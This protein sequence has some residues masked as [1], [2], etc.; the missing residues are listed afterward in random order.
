MCWPLQE[1]T[2]RQRER[3]AAMQRYRAKKKDKFLKLC[4]RTS[5]GQPVMKYHMHFLL[6]KLEKQHKEW[7]QTSGSSA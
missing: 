5:K 6:E 3:E 2:Q 1:M 4:K 7:T